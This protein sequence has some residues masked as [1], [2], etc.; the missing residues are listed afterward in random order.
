MEDRLYDAEAGDN[1]PKLCARDMDRRMSPTMHPM[2][3]GLYNCLTFALIL[4][5]VHFAIKNSSS[6]ERWTSDAV[7][8]LYQNSDVDALSPPYASYTDTDSDIRQRRADDQKTMMLAY[9]QGAN[10]VQGGNGAQGGDDGQGL[11]GMSTS[12]PV[13]AAVA[14]VPV[15]PVHSTFT[16]TGDAGMSDLS[17]YEAS[18]GIGG[19]LL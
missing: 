6:A 16:T 3:Q 4:L 15:Y 8:M 1:L 12:S 10:G 17:G 11:M 5:I 19:M 7:D 9:V 2:A 14:T 13:P 18:P